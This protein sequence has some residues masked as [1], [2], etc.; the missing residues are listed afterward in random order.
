MGIESLTEKDKNYCLAVEKYVAELTEKRI[1]LKAQYKLKNQR[2]KFL[3]KMG[4]TRISQLA[5]L[6][7]LVLDVRTK[8]IIKRECV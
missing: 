1:V 7:Q 5:L 3:Q 2:F 6:T 4:R 8:Y